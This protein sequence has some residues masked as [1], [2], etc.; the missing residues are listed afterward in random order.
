MCDED[1]KETDNTIRQ[2]YLT[3]YQIIKNTIIFKSSKYN[4]DVWIF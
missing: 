4:K 2:F 3:V 1:N